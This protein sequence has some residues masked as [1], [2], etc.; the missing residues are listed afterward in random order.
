MYWHINVELV[1]TVQKS[2]SIIH[3]CSF[4]HLFSVMGYHRVLNIVLC[5][6]KKD[7]VVS[8]QFVFVKCTIAYFF[9]FNDLSFK[10]YEIWGVNLP[11]LVSWLFPMM[12]LLWKSVS[13]SL[14]EKF[15]IIKSSSI[16]LLGPLIATRGCQN[17]WHAKQRPTDS[18]TIIFNYIL[19]YC[20]KYFSSRI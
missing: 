10:S 4:L 16:C 1:S 17:S 9:S 11:S 7:F 2:D 13:L 12:L 15:N 20:T 5:A 6:L 14:W 18:S 19:Y 8:P 3:M